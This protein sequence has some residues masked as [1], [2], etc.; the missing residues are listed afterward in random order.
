MMQETLENQTKTPKPLASSFQYSNY[1]IRRKVL[2]LF[3]ENLIS[4]PT[5]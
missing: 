4:T 2:K 1:V 5:W 3:G